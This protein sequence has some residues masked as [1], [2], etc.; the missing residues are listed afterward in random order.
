MVVL[1][2]GRQSFSEVPFPYGLCGKQRVSRELPSILPESVGLRRAGLNR[3][4]AF[5]GRGQ[6]LVKLSVTMQPS[7]QRV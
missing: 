6:Q 3:L 1:V 4:L 2:G 5:V 7:Q